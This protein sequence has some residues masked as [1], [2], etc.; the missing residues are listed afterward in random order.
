MSDRFIDVSI[1]VETGSEGDENQVDSKPVGHFTEC[2]KIVN[3]PSFSS[4]FT[5]FSSRR[6]YFESEEI[7]IPFSACPWP[8]LMRG[9]EMHFLWTWFIRSHLIGFVDLFLESRKCHFDA[10]SL[11][12]VCYSLFYFANIFSVHRLTANDK[13]IVRW[14]HVTTRRRRNLFV[15]GKKFSEN[16]NENLNLLIH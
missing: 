1:Q 3:W 16:H 11:L 5:S 6:C 4:A 10:W 12:S 7:S 8:I 9:K 2:I 14:I 13:R 15:E